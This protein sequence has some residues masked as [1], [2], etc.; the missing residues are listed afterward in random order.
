[1]AEIATRV[2]IG[3]ALRT[4]LADVAAARHDQRAAHALGRPARRARALPGQGPLERPLARRPA[5]AGGRRVGRPGLRNAA[6]QLDAS[7]SGGQAQHRHARRPARPARRVRRAR[8]A[9]RPARRQLTWKI[10]RAANGAA[11]AAHGAGHGRDLRQRRRQGRAERDLAHGGRGNGFGRGGRYPG[12]LELD[13]RWPTA[14]PR[15]PRATCR[16]ACPKARAA[17]SPAPCARARSTSAT[18]RVRG[19]LCGLPVPRR[20]GRARRRVPH[21]RQG[22]GPDLRLRAG[23]AGVGGRSGAGAARDRWPPFTGGSGELVVDRS[24]LEIRDAKAQLGNVEWSALQGRIAELGSNAAARHRG[25]RARPARR[26]AALRRRRRRSAAGPARRSPAAT[27]TGP[28]ELKLAL[29]IPLARPARPAVKGSLAL[30]GNDVRMTPD[31]PLLAAAQGARRFHAEGLSSSARRA[32]TR[33]AARSPSRAARAPGLNGGDGQRFSGRGTATRRGAAPG[34]RARRGRAPRRLARPARRATAAR[35]PSSPAGRRSRHEQP[36]RPRHRPARAA[37]ARR[38]R[39]RSACACARRPKTALAPTG[40]ARRRCARPCRS[41]SAACCRRSSCARRAARRRASFAARSASARRAAIAS[42]SRCRATC[43]IAAAAGQRRRR[44]RRRQAA[45]RRRLA[46]RARATAGRAGASGDRAQP[47][48]RSSSMPAAAPATFP[49][50]SRCGSA[51]SR[52]ARAGS[53]TS[54]RACRRQ[55]ELWRANVNADQLDGYVEYRPARRGGAGAGRVFARLARLSLPKGEA[56]KVE[57]LLDEPPTSIPALDVVVDDFELRG[58]RLGRLEI[59]ATNRGAGDARRGARMAARQAQP[60]DAR[61]A[62]RRHRHLGQRRL[63]RRGQCAASRGDG[64]QARAERQRRAARAARHG[65]RD[66]RRQGLAH[67]PGVVARLAVV[68]RLPEHDR[69]RSRWRSTRA[70]S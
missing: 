62:V 53:T 67:R 56:E 15:A 39:R 2:P 63:G 60:D 27:A 26:D 4:L 69:Q 51:S 34:A 8:A 13:G 52:S 57:S 22:R 20:Q 1:M 6:L 14:S 58:K 10:E 25:H 68:A 35:S 30:A 50:R 23:R 29:A 65:P 12:V 32:R 36:R 44:Q 41:I 70:S 64:L 28:A 16:S 9:A 45:R 40:D 43:S 5:G 54:P 19:D 37:R 24:T 59:E 49:M 61:G 17:T 18:F 31:T 3:A 47:R 66:P 42:S 48:C 21:R 55:G 7:E 38:R 46:G 11:A 33:S